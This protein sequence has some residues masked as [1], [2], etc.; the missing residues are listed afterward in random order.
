ML[1]DAIF[2]DISLPGCR[3]VTTRRGAGGG[4]YG[5]FNACH[6]VGDNPDHVALSRA[7]LARYFGVEPSRLVIPRQ[8]HSSIVN[9][10]NGTESSAILEGVDGI[11]TTAE[12][13]VLCVNTA[14]CVPVLLVDEQA[15]V[16]AAVHSGWRGTVERI[17]AVAVGEMCR[18]GASP[19]RIK[20]AMGPCICRT[21]FEV[22]EEVTER[23]VAEFPAQRDI[24]I[25]DPGKRDHIDLGVAI[26]H[27]LEDAGVLREHISQP[28]AC[29]HC[30]GSPYFSARRLGV[31]SGRSLTAIML[32]SPCHAAPLG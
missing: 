16:I 6:Y 24:V 5:M 27:T 28:I 19:H 10:V 20:V 12:G 1:N 31:A 17:S 15:R 4:L 22:G 29:S 23:F 18:L 32:S 26:R 9:V 13:V 25:C 7:A 2:V 11:V 3:A 8:T 14:D 21:C 30:A